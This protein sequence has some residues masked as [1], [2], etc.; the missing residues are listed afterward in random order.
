MINLVSLETGANSNTKCSHR[1]N[2]NC[3]GRDTCELMITTALVVLCAFVMMRT[4]IGRQVHAVGGNAK[5]GEALDRT[6]R[7]ALLT[8]VNMACWRRSPASSLPRPTC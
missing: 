3:V 1:N 7:L 5:G 8:F 2:N 4:I 6:E